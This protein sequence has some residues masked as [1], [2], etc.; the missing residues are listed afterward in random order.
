M[1][2]SM[3]LMTG[4]FGPAKTF[5]MIPISADCPFLEAIFYPQNNTLAI[6]SKEKKPQLHMLAKLNEVGDP[7]YIKP[8]QKIVASNGGILVGK[9]E[10]G[11]DYAEERKLLDTYYEY[12]I[13]EKDEIL[14][15][16]KMAA[17]NADKYPFESFFT[18]PEEESLK[19]AA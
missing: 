19:E 2:N 12:Y 4:Q 3:F 14:A 6:V 18:E 11:K 5:K 9:R 8:N 16:V 13:E 1:L 10:N 15:F 17:I 7:V